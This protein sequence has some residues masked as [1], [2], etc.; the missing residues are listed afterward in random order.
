[1]TGWLVYVTEA[2]ATAQE[3]HRMGLVLARMSELDA[4]FPKRGCHFFHA[5][6]VKVQC[7]SAKASPL[8]CKDSKPDMGKHATGSVLFA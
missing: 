3:L 2:A 4:Y 7:L 6:Q 1:M 8:K 5:S